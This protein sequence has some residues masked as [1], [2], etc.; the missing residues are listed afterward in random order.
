MVGF[1][2]S[3]HDSVYAGNH[4]LLDFY[5]IS[6]HGTKEEISAILIK[7]AEETG[8]TVLFNHMHPFDGG[9]LSGVVVL[10]ESHISIHIWEDEKFAALDIFVCGTCD[11]QKA[12][13]IL[14]DFFKPEKIVE[15]T[16]RRGVMKR[17]ELDN[18]VSSKS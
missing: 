11:P 1:I 12:L 17:S 5:G 6:N 3:N 10:A 4:L 8:A 2:N 14:R 13:P 9:G 15:S 7:A 18:Y 16:S